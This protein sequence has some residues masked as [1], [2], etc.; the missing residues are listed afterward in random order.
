VRPGDAVEVGVVA[1]QVRQ[2]VGLHDGDDQGV[3]D[4]QA[5]LLAQGQGRRN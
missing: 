2:A 1:G 5:V 4:Q 3:I